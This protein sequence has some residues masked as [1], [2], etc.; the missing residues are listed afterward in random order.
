MLLMVNGPLA[1]RYP[2]DGR[3]GSKGG[4]GCKYRSSIGNVT[5]DC[6]G[7]TP[8]YWGFPLMG[9]GFI[10]TFCIPRNSRNVTGVLFLRGEPPRFADYHFSVMYRSNALPFIGR[11][12]IPDIAIG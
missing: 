11:S 9:G 2:R 4:I 12:S 6:G 5:M 10:V 8:V 1:I 7:H 3:L